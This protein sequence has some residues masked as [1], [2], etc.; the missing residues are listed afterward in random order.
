MQILVMVKMS[1]KVHLFLSVFGLDPWKYLVALTSQFKMPKKVFLH[2]R[3]IFRC[4]YVIINQIC[5]FLPNYLFFF[6]VWY[7][8]ENWWQYIDSWFC[9]YW[10]QW[11]FPSFELISKLPGAKSSSIFQFWPSASKSFIILSHFNGYPRTGQ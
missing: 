7:F 11:Q 10:R 6:Q 8:R 5:T 2:N 3:I 4:M 9:F 1:F